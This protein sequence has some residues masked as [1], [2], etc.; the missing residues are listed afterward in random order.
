MAIKLYLKPS[1]EKTR[2]K[3][4]NF[5]NKTT[6]RQLTATDDISLTPKFFVEAG[7]NRRVKVKW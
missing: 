2:N 4:D 5:A 7:G 6:W 3:R 1:A